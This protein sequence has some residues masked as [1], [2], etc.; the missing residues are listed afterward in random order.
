MIAAYTAIPAT[1]I[2][3]KAI[4]HTAKVGLCAVV[5]ISLE[6]VRHIIIK[7]TNFFLLKTYS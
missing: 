4:T 7:N 2:E 3:A 1:K 5:A 6:R